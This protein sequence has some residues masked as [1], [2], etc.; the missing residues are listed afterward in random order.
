VR[1]GTGC[2]TGAAE[3]IGAT[4]RDVGVDVPEVL[5]LGLAYALFEKVKLGVGGPF[6]M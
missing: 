1:A 5:V 2:E 3:R 6:F 4:R